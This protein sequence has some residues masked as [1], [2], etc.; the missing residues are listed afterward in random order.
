MELSIVKASCNKKRRNRTRRRGPRYWILATF[1][2]G[3][4]V[5]FTMGNS[6]HVSVAYAEKV[7]GA[8]QL[9]RLDD[10]DLE[11]IDLN[12]PS[13]AMGSVIAE[14][15]K[16]AG[17]GITVP[18]EVLTIR[19]PGVIGRYTIVQALSLILDGTGV[20]YTLVDTRNFKLEIKA[21][22]ASV[23]VKASNADTLASSKYP[24][25]LRNIPQTINVVPKDVIEQQGAT[26]LREVLNN[27]PGITFNAGEGGTPAGDNL[28]IRGFSARNDIYVDGARDLGPQ[29]RDSFNLEQVEVVKGPSSTFTGRGST[30]GTI[31]LINKLPN[32]R[33]T[34]GATVTGGNA[35]T[36]R[37]TGDMN[38]PLT[39]SI[40]FRLNVM[41]HDSGV[42]ERDVVENK[43]W[44]FAPSLGFGLTGRTRFTASYYYLGENNISD[45]GIPWVPLANNA[46]VAFRDKLAPVPRNT[47]YGYA[48]KDREHLTSQLATFRFEHE[49]ND[50]LSV[51]NQLR[52][53]YSR[54]D[55]IASP[56]RFKDNSS[57]VISRE[58][59]SWITGDGI[60]DNQTDF[61]YRLKTGSLQ[62][63][64]VFGTSLSHETNRRVLRTGTDATTTM[65]YPNPYD[66]YTG[67]VTYDARR[68]FANAN[69]I[70][71]YLFD[72][73]KFNKY[74]DLSGGFRFDRF[75]ATGMNTAT[76]VA[77]LVPIDRT[78]K[79]SSGRA[80]VIF[81]PTELGSVY[82]SYGTS[83][84]PSLEGLLYS[85]ADVRTP[86]ETTRTVE[87]GTKWELL[88]AR[89]LLTGAVFRVQKNNA[90]TP[91]LVAGEPPT[92]DGDQ[93]ISGLEFGATGNITR[94]WQIMSAYTFLDSK[95]LRSNTA[96]T[97]VNGILIS[98][99][100]KQLINTPRNSF[101]LWTTY[102]WKSLFF[103]GGPRYVGQRF[104]NNINTRFVPSYWVVDAVGSYQVNTHIA[105]QMNLSNLGD[106]FYLDR[107]S[108]GHAVPG[109][110]RLA[111][112]STRFSF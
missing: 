47:F 86:P 55:S 49:F 16:Q 112:V 17:I 33:R 51:R 73:I 43:R 76:G 8:Y 9:A 74:I 70:A 54:R 4:I 60:W 93:Q 58:Y 57:T 63:T 12:I 106:T 71:A 111:T 59:K 82:L 50:N 77:A 14:F 61:T 103:G 100:G 40:A 69:S 67:V 88:K 34:F 27:V 26:T 21:E 96:P 101:S 104:G 98:E 1:A 102:R 78:D 32:L 105:I 44:G 109:A 30:G 41:G 38:L 19:S 87:A 81:H 53:G 80:A 83:A 29:S 99:Q 10:N 56:G 95:I 64:L 92:L 39:E 11:K 110:G 20:S 84:D 62:H 72:T 66:L 97:N 15:E 91:S 13:G 52:Y 36:K 18:P 45:Y 42:V 37:V 68:P 31:N 7:N 108:G 94:E 65:L 3:A 90:R 46:L 22:S 28:N 107:L 5:A 75:S 35:G 6:R 23:D 48:N 24:D 25:V 79:L 85:P 2:S 89:L